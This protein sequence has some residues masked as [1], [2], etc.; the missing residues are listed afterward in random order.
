MI[1]KYR[2]VLKR[3]EKYAEIYDSELSPTQKYLAD[4]SLIPF[5]SVVISINARNQIQSITQIPL[6]LEVE[7][8]PFSIISFE[9]ICKEKNITIITLN[10]EIQE[11]YIF[12]GGEKETLQSFIT[13]VEEKNPDILC[14]M[15]SDMKILIRLSRKN[16]LPILGKITGKSIHL[17]E[18]RIFLDLVTYRRMS[19]A[20]MVERIQYTREV[21]RLSSN[22]AAGRAIESRQCYEARRHGILLPRNGFFQ[23][24]MSLDKLLRERDHGGLIFAPTVGLHT[25]VAAL[26]FES[27][28]PHLI[29]TKNISYEN[30]H[31]DKKNDGFLLE[32]TSE[33]LNR[34]LH[35]KHLRKELEGK[36]QEWFWCETRQQ[37]LKEILFC[38]YG[39]SGCWAN[40]F[41]NMDTFMEINK[42]ARE[43]LVSAMNIAR[44]HGYKTLYGNNDSLFLHKTGA[45]RVNYDSLADKI[46]E[47]LDLPIT[48]ENHFKYLVLLPQKSEREFG[49]INRYYGL[50][51]DGELVC[52]GIELRRRNT[53]PY[54]VSIQTEALFKLLNQK[55]SKEVLTKGIKEV[56]KVISRATRALSQRA[57]PI[58]ELEIQTILRR[59]PS[60]YKSRLPHVAAAEAMNING[61]FVERGSVMNYIYVDSEH[62]NP[63][64]RV[65]PAGY[66][67]TYDKAKYVKLLKEA[68]KSILLPFLSK[69]KESSCINTLDSF[70]TL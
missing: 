45:T 57:V 49:A 63:F 30:L 60:K 3:L 43:S 55:T 13:F 64:R 6:G 19:L 44:A 29:L 23:P 58:E 4:R 31:K 62:S 59:R 46:A 7:P 61:I 67:T 9:L 37:A 10:E 52:R 56:E 14:C 33:T 70:F 48:V 25:N 2:T 5:G 27:M 68:E 22:W 42:V 40:K 34:R 36:P 32:F 51:Y 39:Y 26:D 38:T 66:S 28:F 41:G 12:T 21:P 53:P 35:Y 1:E 11:E 69:E 16:G 20:G 15:E 24:V 17:S 18:G 8:P 65:T 54:I 50:N 47:N